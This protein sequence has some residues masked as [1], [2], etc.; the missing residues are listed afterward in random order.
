MPI[1]SFMH[2]FSP[3]S[4]SRMFYVSS[5]FL[6]CHLLFF[7]YFHVSWYIIFILFGFL[8]CFLFHFFS[9]F[10]SYSLFIFIS[11]GLNFCSF[12]FHPF[13]TDENYAKRKICVT[14]FFLPFITIPFSASYFSI[15]C[16]LHKIEPRSHAT[17]MSVDNG[18][19]ISHASF[20]FTFLCLSNWPNF[21]LP[22]P[23]TP[24]LLYYHSFSYFIFSHISSY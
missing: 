10:T 9:S 4:G 19:T 5:F 6:I 21:F 12:I 7:V 16:P 23:R 14:V 15:L 3:F 2:A 17:V 13:L 18:T 11:L 1:L 24:I 22:I 8:L 20:S